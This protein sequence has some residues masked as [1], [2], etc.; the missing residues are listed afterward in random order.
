MKWLSIIISL[1]NDSKMLEVTLDSLIQQNNDI[2][3]KVE[4]LIFD[5]NSKDNPYKVLS[6]YQKSIN[7]IFKSSY[8]NLIYEAWNKALSIAKGQYIT[9]LGAGDTLTPLSL[10]KLYSKTKNINKNTI[11][12][13]QSILV[14]REKKN[15]LSGEKF[16]FNR[17]KNKFTTNHSMLMYSE[18]IFKKYGNFS[19]EYGESGD[20]EFLLRIGRFIKAKHLNYPT[21]KYLV[22]GIS[23]RNLRPILMD[24]KI[25]RDYKFNTMLIDLFLL[26]KSLF[27]FYF[28]LLIGRSYGKKII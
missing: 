24:F 27:I 6:R 1:K 25:R 8:D 18:D 7:I 4:I 17:F 11:L 19:L 22:G 16:I 20:Y 2:L 10:E 12:T 21:C 3:K 28:R 14:T 23:S 15:F 13:S 26:F 5:S 9:F